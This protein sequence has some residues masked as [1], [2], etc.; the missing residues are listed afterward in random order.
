[1]NHYCGRAELGKERWENNEKDEMGFERSTP[2]WFAPPGRAPPFHWLPITLPK[3]QSVDSILSAV[4]SGLSLSLGFCCYRS[5][6]RPTPS[7]TQAIN[8]RRNDKEG[9]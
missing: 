4:I 1:V 9:W 2:S 8:R 5:K 7:L 6:Y 3:N